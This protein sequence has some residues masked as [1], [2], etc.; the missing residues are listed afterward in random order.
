MPKG[1]RS[2]CFDRFEI[3]TERAIEISAFES[4]KMISCSRD[5]GSGLNRA[6]FERSFGGVI[7]GIG[8]DEGKTREGVEMTFEDGLTAR[9][10]R[11]R[12]GFKPPGIRD[13]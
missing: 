7:W 1:T 11:V 10:A 3:D 2:V 8:G 4:D 9:S 12:G 6:D 5:P 13:W